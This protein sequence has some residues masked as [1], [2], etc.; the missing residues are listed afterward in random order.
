MTHEIH[1]STHVNQNEVESHQK[2]GW[3]INTYEEWLKQKTEQLNV[4]PSQ[5]VQER[6]KPGRK[7]K[8]Q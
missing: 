5:D 1:G 6:K 3:K 2:N 4:I 7:P 8:A